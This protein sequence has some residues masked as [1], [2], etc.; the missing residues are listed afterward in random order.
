[1]AEE[2]VLVPKSKYD[3]LLK[4]C[5]QY[6]ESKQIGGQLNQESNQTQTK[7]ETETITTTKV[8]ETKNASSEEI[9]NNTSMDNLPKHDVMPRTQSKYYVEKPLSE[10]NFNK[11]SAARTGVAGPRQKKAKWINYN[12]L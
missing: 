6:N 10:M 3:F 4:Q 11:R 8:P 2:H 5:E 12:V 9:E 1:M 7:D